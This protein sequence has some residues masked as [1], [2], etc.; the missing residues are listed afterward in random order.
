MGLPSRRE[1]LNLRLLNPAL[2][3]KV[4]IAMSDGHSS[5]GEIWVGKQVLAFEPAVYN[6]FRRWQ[7]FSHS[8]HRDARYET[9][10]LLTSSHK[11]CYVNKWICR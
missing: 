9:L 2:K 7:L 10:Q 11:I 1:N 5:R 8:T 4:L 6:L 3:R